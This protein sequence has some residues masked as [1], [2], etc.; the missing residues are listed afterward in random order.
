MQTE[1]S[2]S[3]PNGDGLV[4]LQDYY[5]GL[6]PAGPRADAPVTI[7]FDAR[8]TFLDILRAT[9]VPDLGVGLL[10]ST[11]LLAWEE[12]PLIPSAPVLLADGR[13]LDRYPVPA[14][15]IRRFYRLL[16]TE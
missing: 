14:A 15:E 12:S 16:L 13:F 1:P 2:N 5:S 8:G 7:A 4:L 10:E 9:G 3:D 11:T 6:D